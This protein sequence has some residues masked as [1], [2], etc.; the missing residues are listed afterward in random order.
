M[1]R[2]AFKGEQ[3]QRMKLV[4][5]KGENVVTPENCRRREHGCLGRVTDVATEKELRILVCSPVR[6]NVLR[7]VWVLQDKMICLIMNSE[8]MEKV[9]LFLLR[10]LREEIGNYYH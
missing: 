2:E 4:T 8:K 5:V 9:R 1:E 10:E 3:C 7:L 6:W